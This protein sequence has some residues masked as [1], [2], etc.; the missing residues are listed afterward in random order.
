MHQKDA[1]VQTTDSR[2]QLVRAT[3]AN[4]GAT[5]VMMAGLLTASVDPRGLISQKLRR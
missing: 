4:S 1:A 3:I 5:G 2:F